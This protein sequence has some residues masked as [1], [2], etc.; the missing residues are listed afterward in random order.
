M[1][2]RLKL[3]RLTFTSSMMTDLIKKHKLELIG[4]L[5]GAIAGY[6]YYAKVGCVTGSCAI[7]SS[8]IN[9]SLYGAL[10]GYLLMGMFKKENKEQIN[11]E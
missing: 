7:T 6:V 2:H 10:L 3:A 9:S 1:S 5:L 8:P 11:K 4:I